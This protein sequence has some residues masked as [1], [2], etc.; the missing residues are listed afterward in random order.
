[1]VEYYCELCEYKKV[2]H[3]KCGFKKHILSKHNFSNEKRKYKF[4][5]ELCAYTKLYASK[6]GL[7]KHVLSKHNFSYK[8]SKL[9]QC[10]N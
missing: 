9:N 6:S 5:C 1:M 4:G 3:S 2:F 8:K 7:K 10:I